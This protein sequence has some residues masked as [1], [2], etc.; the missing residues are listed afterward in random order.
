MLEIYTDGSCKGNGKENSSGGY[1]VV[2]TKNNTIIDVYT[3]FESKTTNNIMEMKAVLWTMLKYGSK[4]E[5]NIPIVY[6]D[7]SYVVNTFNDWMFR[8]AKNN[9]KKSDKKTPENLNLITEYYSHFN[10]GYRINLQ[11]VKGHSNNHFNELA[12]KLA[13]Q[14][15]YIKDLDIENVKE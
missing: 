13:T 5:D 9:W 11:K 14:S 6:C 15:I 1:A 4:N 2:I 12:D 7:S 8:W 10:K 3:H